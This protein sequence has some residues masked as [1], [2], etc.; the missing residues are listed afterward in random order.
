MEAEEVKG[1]VCWIPERISQVINKEAVS[2]DRANFLATHAPLSHIKYERSPH[3]ITDTSE[4]ALLNELRTYAIENRHAFT[5][6]QGIPGT[7]KSHLIRW[8]KERYAAGGKESG[9]D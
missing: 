7:G 2:V 5:V 3:A 9:G 1:V 4:E 6:I 8:L